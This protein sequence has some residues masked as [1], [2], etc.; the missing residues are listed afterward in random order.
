MV[1][2][3]Q[4]LS[5]L[6][7]KGRNELQTELDKATSPKQAVKVVQNQLD[8]LEKNYIG[9]LSVSQVR[10]VNFFLDTLRQSLSITA[11]NDTSISDQALDRLEQQESP[12]STLSFILKLLQAIVCIC[13]LVALFSLTKTAP[14]AWMPI[15]LISVLIGLEVALQFDQ[16]NQPSSLKS[17]EV[18]SPQVQID[19]KILLDNLE[20]ALSTI[21]NAVASYEE[22][23]YSLASSGLEDLTE[24][25]DI[26]QRLWGASSLEN[27]LMTLELAKLIPQILLKQGIRV[28]TYRPNDEQSKSEYFDFEPSIDPSQSDYV[29]LT[30][31]LLKG[32]RLLCRGRVIEPSR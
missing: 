6:F 23:N 8:R 21:D 19:S 30:P 3:M 4:T 24:I 17:E 14:A 22:V 18:H 12:K 16:K 5:T 25:L 1:S 15:L 13:I 20:N 29:T 11:T 2:K 32:E 9:D 31:A 27:P 26:L 7:S 10:L 28:Q